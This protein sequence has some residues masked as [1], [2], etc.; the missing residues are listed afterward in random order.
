MD[1]AGEL[2]QDVYHF[3]LLT[4]VGCR[5]PERT[6]HRRMRARRQ[7]FKAGGSACSRFLNGPPFQGIARTRR[8]PYLRRV[9]TLPELPIGSIETPRDR[10]APRTGPRPRWVVLPALLFLAA[11]TVRSTAPSP[12]DGSPSTGNS[13]E[14]RIQVEVQ[15]MNFN[16]ITVYA[17]RS[18]QRLR[19]GR[20]TGKT[21]ETI[22]VDWNLAIPI[23]FE[24]DVVGG[25]QC[26]TGQV[27]LDRSA[28][29]WLNVPS[30]VAV[31]PCRTGR[32]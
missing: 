12:F 9:I 29:V 4:T 19:I 5:I 6:G 1:L 7:L 17:L 13:A 15:N 14:S 31:Q 30:N 23:S 21:T 25:R 18:G 27:G 2:S 11:C 28:R 3:V 20:V 32:V 10:A 26:R 24:V 8:T 16:D 22:R